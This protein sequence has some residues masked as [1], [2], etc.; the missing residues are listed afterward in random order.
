MSELHE[1]R[2]AALAEEA[3]TPRG[4]L[5]HGKFQPFAR[6]NARGAKHDLKPAWISPA[7]RCFRWEKKRHGKRGV[8]GLKRWLKRMKTLVA[9]VGR[10]VALFSREPQINTPPPTPCN[11]IRVSRAL[12][13]SSP[14]PLPFHPSSSTDGTRSNRWKD[15]IAARAAGHFSTKPTSLLIKSSMKEFYGAESL[16]KWDVCYPISW[17]MIFN[18]F[19][20]FFRNIF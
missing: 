2:R 7:T 14:P 20:F 10:Y 11:A 3:T 18:F 15:R 4:V 19:L 6:V 5:I 1:G 12:T 9:A 17:E 16:W 13:I 8:R